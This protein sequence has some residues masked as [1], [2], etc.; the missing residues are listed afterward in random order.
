MNDMKNR[1]V[2]YS[3]L[4]HVVILGLLFALSFTRGGKNEG[5]RIYNVSI[6]PGVAGAGSGGP[7][8]GGKAEVGVAGMVGR[9]GK[10]GG[11]ALP[12][13]QS[14]KGTALVQETRKKP[15]TRPPKSDSSPLDATADIAMRVYGTGGTIGG[16]GQ[17]GGVPGGTGGAEGR[18]A[19]AFEIAMNGKI[20]ANWNEDLWK[21]LPDRLLCTVRFLISADGAVSNIEAFESSGNSSFDLAAKRAVALANMPSPAAFGMPGNIH[22]ARVTFVNRPE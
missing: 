16:G 7:G 10:I 9:P 2:I 22:E 1:S 18:P 6:I 20:I 15:A 8:S 13:G 3:F 19:S 12:S 5:A 17:P 21:V 4:G 14:P 11:V